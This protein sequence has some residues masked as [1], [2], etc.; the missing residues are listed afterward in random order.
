MVENSPS[1][2]P[3]RAIYGFV[4]FVSSQSGFTVYFVWAKLLRLTYQPQNFSFSLSNEYSG[5]SYVLLAGINM[6]STSLYLQ[7]EDQEEATPALREI[8]I[9]EV[10]QML[11]L[12]VKELYTK[13]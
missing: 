9:S 1:P 6:M 11:F 12:A 8:S 7:K 10:N 3:E 2:L 5:I 13:T 4:L